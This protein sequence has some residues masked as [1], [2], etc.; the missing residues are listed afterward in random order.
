M[1]SLGIN[2][3]IDFDKLRL[4]MVQEQLSKREIYDEGVIAAMRKVPRHEFVLPED[5]LKSYE[6]CPLPIGQG[7]TISQPYMVALM[8]QCLQLKKTDRVF[9][10]GTGSGYQSAVLAELCQQVFTIER[11]E[12]LS[13]RAEKIL[14]R[15]GYKNINFQI[16]D[17]SLGWG[18]AACLFDG[19]IVTAAASR[20]SAQEF[21][22]KLSPS[23][24]RLVIP[25]G[26][27]GSQDLV[28]FTKRE[29]DIQEE[30]VC[31]CVFVPLIGQF[32]LS[33]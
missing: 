12:I 3:P 17:G 24:G 11:I 32:G 20:T 7:Q 25:I 26:N 30:M 18:D 16:G 14:S 15:L 1:F 13:Q 21:L 27:R 10:I 6:D 31:R 5:K 29:K 28:L 2:S 22:K 9:E 23:G 19:I 8:T 33:T 4:F